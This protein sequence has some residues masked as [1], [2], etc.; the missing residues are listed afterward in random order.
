MAPGQEGRIGNSD[1]ARGDPMRVVWALSLVVAYLLMPA[2]INAEEGQIKIG[3]S[4]PLSGG[5]ASEGEDL[6]KIL[7]F[8]NE[9]LFQGRYALLFEDDKCSNKDAVAVATKLATVDLVGAVIGYA[10]SGA[11]LSA[12]P[13]LEKSKT[14]TFGLAT[15]APEISNAGDYIFRT[16]PSLEVAAQRLADHAGSRVKKIAILSEET[17][18]CR[19]LADAFQRHNKDRLQIDR[20]DYLPETTDFRSLLLKLKGQGN[21]AI[22]L[23]PQDEQGMI[24][25]YRQFLDLNWDVPIYAAYYP[26]FA[27]FRKTFGIKG[28]GIIFAD[29]PFIDSGLTTTGKTL[30][31]KYVAKNGKPQSSEFYFVTALSAF[32]AVNQALQSNSDL[33]T[34][35]YSQRLNGVFGEFSFDSHGDVVGNQLTFILKTLKEGSPVPVT[36]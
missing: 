25:L 18:Y 11:I 6:R 17:A 36:S 31:A 29:L 21:Q 34:F 5:A 28:D 30:Y 2:I 3:V 33:R 26:G 27:D 10:C 9:E 15:G 20:L 22:F 8:A 35:L 4:L 32:E 16:I 13:V 14:V 1:K 7:T 24:K 19:S 12:A 23:N